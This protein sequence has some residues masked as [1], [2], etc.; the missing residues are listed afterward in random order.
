M[1]S[2]ESIKEFDAPAEASI[3]A[4]RRASFSGFIAVVLQALA[5]LREHLDG[6]KAGIKPGRSS[7]PRWPADKSAWTVAPKS[8]P[9][10]MNLG[11]AH[12]KGMPPLDLPF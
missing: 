5:D 4:E 7:V 10:K 8:N 6:E 1:P 2:I 9:W 12:Q 3:E 11:A